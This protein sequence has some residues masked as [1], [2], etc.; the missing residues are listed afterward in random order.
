MKTRIIAAVVLLP[1]L[2]ILLLVLPT[3]CTAVVAGLVCALAAY[4]LLW[5]TGMVRLVRLVA[6]SA[7]MAF[8]IAIW[9]QL[10][11]SYTAAFLGILIYTALMFGELLGAKGELPF[12]KLAVCFIGALLIPLMLSALVRILGREEG[13]IFV[14]L[15]FLLAFTSDSGAYFAGRFFGKHKLAPVIS[16]NK[17]IEGVAGGVLGAI[18]GMLVYCII[19]DMFFH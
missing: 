17:T 10:G 7:V 6:Y 4:E 15:P 16:P 5:G 18:V 19:L 13:R 12:E 11:M 3:V 1:L 14:L 9:C 8:L 2:L